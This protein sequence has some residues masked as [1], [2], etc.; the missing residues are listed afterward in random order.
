MGEGLL[1][2]GLTTLDILGRPIDAIPVDGRGQLIEQIEIVPAGTAGGTA[3]VAA[4]LGVETALVSALGAD[5][6]GDLVRATYTHYGV[7]TSLV[8]SVKEARSS[9]TILTIDSAGRRPTFH[10]RGASA[11]TEL[12][13]AALAAACRSRFIH[14]AAIGAPR[15]GGPATAAFLAAARAAGAIVTCDLISPNRHS[16]I[17]LEAILPHIDYF[18]PSQTEAAYL[19]GQE[20]ERVAAREF[21]RLGARACIV[22]RGERGWL[23]ADGAKVLEGPALGIDVVD[24]TSCGDAFCAGFIAALDAGW[25]I[26]RAC[27]FANATAALVAQGLGTLGKLESFAQVEMTMNGASG[28]ATP[29]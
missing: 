16:R 20:D 24:T 9:A 21:L 2:I 10:A 29:P 15:I 17:E 18:M 22:K 8:P 23:Y 11:L 5:R 3:L 27:R 26:E 28:P 14:W 6:I 12:G 1:C 4:V 13:D 7:D 25:P 19:T